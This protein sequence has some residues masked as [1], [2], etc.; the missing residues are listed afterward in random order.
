MRIIG[1]YG[2]GRCGK[3]ETLNELKELLRVAGKSISR[4][5]HSY[6]ESAETFEYKGLVVCVAPAGDTGEIVE[7]N[8]VTLRQRIVMSLF[9]QHAPS[10]ALW[11]H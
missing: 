11:M 3:S 4:K 2:H 8:C 10:W 7:S 6:C 9:L 1:L 5:P